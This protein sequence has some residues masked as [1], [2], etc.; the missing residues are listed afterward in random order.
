M[1]DRQ[2]AILMTN[3]GISL[4]DIQALSL[5]GVRN[6]LYFLTASGPYKKPKGIDLDE[7]QIL[8]SDLAAMFPSRSRRHHHG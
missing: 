3:G 4:A 7:R 1:S 6:L 2:M 8:P 5:H